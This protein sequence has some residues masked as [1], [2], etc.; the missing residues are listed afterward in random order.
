MGWH[1]L[2]RGND[3]GHRKVL[4]GP[5]HMSNAGTW[6]VSNEDGP[7]GTPFL[8]AGDHRFRF[9]NGQELVLNV[10][11]ESYTERVGDMGHDYDVSGHY[12]RVTV[13][14]NGAQFTAD[15]VALHLEVWRD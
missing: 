13:E 12:P 10:R 11:M 14:V 9:P 1:K 2:E 7:D 3:W 8:G 5:R 15:P 4:M 6:G